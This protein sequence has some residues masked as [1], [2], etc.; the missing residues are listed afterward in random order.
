MMRASECCSGR[1]QSL[2]A[3]G[4]SG[5]NRTCS[6][7]ERTHVFPQIRIMLAAPDRYGPGPH[8]SYRNEDHAA[9]GLSRLRAW[10]RF[11]RAAFA[12]IPS[13]SP[14]WV[15]VRPWSLSSRTRRCC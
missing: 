13:F 9:A 1:S 12:L 3:A 14:I 5:P 15:G 7:P 6:Q 11:T 4:R 8:G 10:Q 2:P